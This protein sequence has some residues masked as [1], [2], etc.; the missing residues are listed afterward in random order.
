M[1]IKVAQQANPRRSHPAASAVG[2][3][4]FRVILAVGTERAQQCDAPGEAGA[5]PRLADRVEGKPRSDRR[6]RQQWRGQTRDKGV[7]K[8][9]GRTLRQPGALSA[10][11]P[12]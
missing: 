4:S 8:R 6:S 11:H 9:F 1:T 3:G 5:Q 7:T 10:G 12:V 2:R